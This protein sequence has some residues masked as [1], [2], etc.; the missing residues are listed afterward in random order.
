MSYY[1]RHEFQF[2]DHAIKRIKQRLNLSGKDIW[3]LKEQVLD[4][5]ENST[6]CFETSKT[7]YIHTGKGNIFFVINKINKLI[8]TTTP[9][10]AQ[11]ELELVSY[12]SW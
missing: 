1:Y 8:I 3:E 11:K 10:S 5:I 7:I 12:D 9:I 2:S 6:R 4:L